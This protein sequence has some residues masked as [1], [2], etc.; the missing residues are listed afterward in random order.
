MTSDE[1]LALFEKYLDGSATPEEIKIVLDYKDDFELPAREKH[2][3]TLHERDVRDRILQQVSYTAGEQRT[4]VYSKLFWPTVASVA[5]IAVSFFGF[6]EQ[7]ET[8]PKSAIPP[9][10]VVNTV[11]KAGKANTV[12]DEPVETAPASRRGSP[13]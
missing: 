10:P 12:R 9:K 6:R 1:F 5:L 8:I 13:R 3:L 7:P 4:N 11:P 2:G